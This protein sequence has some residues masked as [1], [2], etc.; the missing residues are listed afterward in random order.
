MEKY[1]FAWKY[2]LN[3]S[4][5]A[6]VTFPHLWRYQDLSSFECQMSQVGVYFDMMKFTI[7][8]KAVNELCH[9]FNSNLKVGNNLTCIILNFS[10]C[11]TIR[12]VNFNNM[13]H[14]IEFLRQFSLL[15][16]MIKNLV[17]KRFYFK[18]WLLNMH[19]HTDT[20][21]IKF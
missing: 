2:S 4:S 18:L 14:R 16:S 1:N 21:V 7:F 10:T 20:Q 19:R 6:V 8:M 15:L 12:M 11:A 5:E 17:I 13:L 3:K 9:T